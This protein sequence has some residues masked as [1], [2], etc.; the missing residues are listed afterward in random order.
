M[1]AIKLNDDHRR[2]IKNSYKHSINFYHRIKSNVVLA[3]HEQVCSRRSV[4]FPGH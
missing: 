1:F 2:G 3:I 4:H